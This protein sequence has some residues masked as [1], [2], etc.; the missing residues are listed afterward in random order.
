M[1]KTPE[2]K[3]VIGSAIEVVQQFLE[4]LDEALHSAGY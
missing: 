4:R 2:E 1:L 3:E